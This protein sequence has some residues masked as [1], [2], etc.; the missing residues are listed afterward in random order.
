MKLLDS[1]LKKKRINYK[2]Y[3]QPYGIRHLD[4]F[5]KYY[6]N[7]KTNNKGFENLLKTYKKRENKRDK[8]RYIEINR[9][10]G[11]AP[12]I[13][14]KDDIDIYDLLLDFK[15]I[16]TKYLIGNNDDFIKIITKIIG[17]K[18]SE[19]TL[20]NYYYNVDE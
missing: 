16:K 19:K 11:K 4:F 6:K 2:K 15:K 13:E 17:T 3:Q 10:L 14:L 1:F 9:F 5:Y 18:Y 20:R 12:T 8:K 7:R